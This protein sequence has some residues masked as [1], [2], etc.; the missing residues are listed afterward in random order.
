MKKALLVIIGAMVLSVSVFAD[1]ASN[2]MGIDKDREKVEK[3]KYLNNKFPGQCPRGMWDWQ[4]LDDLERRDQAK[5]SSSNSGASN[6]G[7]N[8][9]YQGSGRY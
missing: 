7:G 6:Y 3:Y 8:N 5:S 9:N 4:C 1:M 2:L